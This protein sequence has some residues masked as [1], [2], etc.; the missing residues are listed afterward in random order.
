MEDSGRRFVYRVHGF[1]S[2]VDC[3]LVEFLRE[4]DAVSIC[5]WCGL[6]P[7]ESMM[8]LRC[9]CLVCDKCR[10]GICLVHGK[11]VY[12]AMDVELKLNYNVG[13]EKVRCV[14][15]MR[16]CQFE[17]CLSMLSNHLE[18]SCAFHIVACT[19]CW[20]GVLYKD[21]IT[22]YPTCKGESQASSCSSAAQSLLEDLTNA[23]KELDHALELTNIDGEHCELRKVVTSASEVFARLK[24]RLAMVGSSLSDGALALGAL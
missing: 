14:N 8:L 7:R 11:D 16:G 21:M 13:N 22:H 6:V 24:T 4:F 5:S 10:F 17:R 3:R 15:A 12:R 20:R 23:R 2:H 9:G 18:R 19:R 1:G